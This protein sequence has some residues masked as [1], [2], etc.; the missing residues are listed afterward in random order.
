MKTHKGSLPNEANPLVREIHRAFANVKYPGDGAIVYDNSGRHLECNQVAEAFRGKHWSE[1]T[2]EILL[3]HNQAHFF[4][5]PEAYR[6]Y[7]PAYLI[8]IV[9]HYNEIDAAAGSIIFSLRR[10]KSK[11]DIEFY[12]QR[13]AGL[14]EAQVR[15]VISCLEWL[16]KEH[17][18]DFPLGGIDKALQSLGAPRKA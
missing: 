11:A 5:S 16:K 12:R 13:M 3:Y 15:A 1:V 6:F 8:G 9:A 17:A 18:D 2:P 10:P 7:L 14:T 4:F